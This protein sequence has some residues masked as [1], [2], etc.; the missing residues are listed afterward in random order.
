MYVVDPKTGDTVK[1]LRRGTA[2]EILAS[3]VNT[4]LVSTH[5]AKVS[6]GKTFC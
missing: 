3:E 2:G 1:V 6:A 4:P 5:E